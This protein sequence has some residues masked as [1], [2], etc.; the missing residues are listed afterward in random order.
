[1]PTPVHLSLSSQNGGPPGVLDSCSADSY[2][3]LIEVLGLLRG[4]QCPPF[5]FRKAKLDPSPLPGNIHVG[6]GG[7]LQT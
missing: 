5:V 7:L 6:N 3:P 1:M 4:A 2:T